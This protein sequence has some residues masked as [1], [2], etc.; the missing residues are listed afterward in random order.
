M[1]A[2]RPV[3]LTPRRCLLLLTFP[4][5]VWGCTP[6]T[7]PSPSVQ[8]SIS[9]TAPGSRVGGPLP[10][11]EPIALHD[12]SGE[13]ISLDGGWNEV[14]SS[15]RSNL[16]TW[17]IHTQGDCIWGAGQVEE[18]FTGIATSPDRVQSLS[19]RIGSDFAISGEIIW[20]G[21]LPP[22]AIASPIRYSPLRM[23]IEFDDTG[24]VRLREDRE[25]GVRGPRC[26]DPASFCPAPLLLERA[27][28]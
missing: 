3:H 4:A 12:P 22:G 13:R 1:D 10:A 23:F 6:T 16:M 7:T 11:C 21:P 14:P 25:A 20:L 19:G 27:D 17:W 5:L 26:P 2:P 8:P 9:D 18:V 28:Q 15:D 24:W